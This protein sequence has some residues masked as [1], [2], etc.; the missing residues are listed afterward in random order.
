MLPDTYFPV[1]DTGLAI[2]V[3]PMTCLP[4]CRR[5]F[6]ARR[7]SQIVVAQRHAMLLMFALPVACILAVEGLAEHAPSSKH[8]V[9]SLA[10]SGVV[11]TNAMILGSG[12]ETIKNRQS[13]DRA[14]A[15]L[16][17]EQADEVPP[18]RLRITGDGIPGPLTDSPEIHRMFFDATGRLDWYVE[19]DRKNRGLSEQDL[20]PIIWSDPRYGVKYLYEAVEQRACTTIWTVTVSSSE[21][22]RFPR[23]MRDELTVKLVSTDFVCDS[24]LGHRGAQ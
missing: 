19:I 15:D 3:L 20:E 1:N 6:A 9:A 21:V 12:I 18:G 11:L 8:W 17:Q 14:L 24:A 4:G 5:G 23:P 13:F 2:H 7:S 16:I 22:R 10:L